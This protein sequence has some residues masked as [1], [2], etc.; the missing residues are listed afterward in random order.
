MILQICGYLSTEKKVRLLGWVLIF[1][2]YSC[3]FNVDGE[4]TCNMTVLYVSLLLL[5]HFHPF[6]IIITRYVEIICITAEINAV[7]K[8]KY[9]DANS[10]P[11]A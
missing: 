5:C 4:Y 6:Y 11:Y 2:Q 9:A 3:N 1:F 7:D 8:N 10:F